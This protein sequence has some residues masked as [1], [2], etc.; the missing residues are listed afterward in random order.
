MATK[1][2]KRRIHF[3]STEVWEVGSKGKDQLVAPSKLMEHLDAV[4]SRADWQ[5]KLEDESRSQGI[6]CHRLKDKSLQGQFWLDKHDDFPLVG[7]GQS[8]PRPS[9]S[10]RG[11]PGLRNGG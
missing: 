11:I 7:D 1:G 5:R 8:G 3:Y 2:L 4:V 6:L 9:P 10:P